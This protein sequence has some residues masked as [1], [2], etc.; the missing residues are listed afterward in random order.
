MAKNNNFLGFVLLKSPDWVPDL[1]FRTME[2]K[3]GIVP[4]DTESKDNSIF[5]FDWQGM[6]I[7]L[8]LFPAPVPNGEAEQNAGFNYLWHGAAEAV[9]EH[10]AQIIVSVSGD[11]DKLEAAQTFVKV[12]DSCIDDDTVGI[13]TNRIVYEPSFYAKSAGAM[14]KGELP[15]L[16]L[17]WFGLSRAGGILSGYTM[18]LDNFGKH[19]IEVIDCKDKPGNL[20]GFMVN[21]ALY[22][23]KGDV[24]L[25]SG[26][27][28][29]FS[30]DQNLKI[31]L[32]PGVEFSDCDTLKIEYPS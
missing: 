14:N 8:A 23:I 30:E 4:E 18:G 2:E 31:T 10:T 3:W 21:I 28:I 7:S 25:R 20:I 19:E 32:S 17:V 12:C 11:S 29:G 26:E 24:T 9:S 16:D 22:I 1:I 5:V 6:H 15:I 27:T 13:Y